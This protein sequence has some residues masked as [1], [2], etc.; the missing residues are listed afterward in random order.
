MGK[1]TK[2]GKEKP[3]QQQQQ[4]KAAPPPPVTVETIVEE[5]EAQLDDGHGEIGPISFMSTE[6]T[7]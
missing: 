6:G 3:A 4:G 1:A 5:T 2:K 7:N